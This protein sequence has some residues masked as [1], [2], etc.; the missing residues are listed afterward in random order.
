VNP[1]TYCGNSFFAIRTE[2][3]NPFASATVPLEGLGHYDESRNSPG[4]AQVL[5]NKQIVAVFKRDINAKA[6]GI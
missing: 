3:S 2:S 5:F 1:I 4:L 6:D